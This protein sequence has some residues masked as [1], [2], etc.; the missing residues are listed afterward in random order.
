MSEVSPEPRDR[1]RLRYAALVGTALVAAGALVLVLTGGGEDRASAAGPTS[2]CEATLR[3][4]HYTGDDTEH[5]R[6]LL[7]PVVELAPD[8]VAATVRKLR[9][10]E[11]GTAAH[12]RAQELWGYYN[13]NHCCQCL[14]GQYIPTIQEVERKQVPVA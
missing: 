10:S 1:R 4:L 7:R 13:N 5:F 8:E 12:T 3:A 9:A 2:Y 6:S 11:P 14:N